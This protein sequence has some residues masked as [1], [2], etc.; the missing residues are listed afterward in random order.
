MP[1]HNVGW[2]CHYFLQISASC[3]G[4]S[5]LREDNGR[6]LVVVFC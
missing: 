2:E 6:G 3:L 5:D 4:S 1:F